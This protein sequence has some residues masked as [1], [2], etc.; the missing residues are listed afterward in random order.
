MELSFHIPDNIAA[1]LD[2]TA[3]VLSR[4]ALEALA[5]EEFRQG[6]LFKP[7]LR[8]LLWLE[9][10]DQIDTFLKIHGVYEDYTLEELE[11]EIAGLERLGV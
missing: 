10:G 1:R 4:G 9:T 6:H 11:Q 2:A 7:D 3:G 5:A 8:E